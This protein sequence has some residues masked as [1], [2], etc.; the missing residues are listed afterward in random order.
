MSKNILFLPGDGIGPEIMETARR[1]MEWFNDK[2]SLGM[3]IIDDQIGGA[4]YEKYG[5]PLAAETLKKALEVDAVIMGAVGGPKW[6]NISYD[7]RPE[8]GLLEIRKKMGLFANLRP[9]MVFDALID[10]STMKPEVVRGL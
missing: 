10:A 5:T 4:A 3:N 8:A 2:R 6:A 9:A 7:K 1:V